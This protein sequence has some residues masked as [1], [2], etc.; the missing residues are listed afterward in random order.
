MKEYTG[1]VKKVKSANQYEKLKNK[2]EYLSNN[3]NNSSLSN[4]AIFSEL[5]SFLKDENIVILRRENSSYY[6]KR[7]KK[8][9]R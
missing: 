3:L 2:I 9:I 8:I 5:V 7:K 4:D 1:E 6:I